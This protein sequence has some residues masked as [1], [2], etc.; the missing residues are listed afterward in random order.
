MY[1]ELM[2]LTETLCAEGLA[3]LLPL[4]FIDKQAENPWN[5]IQ[6]ERAV[7]EF[8]ELTVWGRHWSGFIVQ[9]SQGD[10]E[11]TINL[12]ETSDLESLRSIVTASIEHLGAIAALSD[13]KV[14][15]GVD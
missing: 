15:V 8:G 9:F 4:G 2:T 5:M 10:R 11:S 14:G 13:F 7:G 3:V 1:S 12:M 6:A